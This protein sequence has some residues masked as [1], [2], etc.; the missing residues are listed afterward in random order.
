MN[1][2]NI[3]QD[4]HQL[5][6]DISRNGDQMLALTRQVADINSGSSNLGGVNKVHDFFDNLFADICDQ[7][8]RVELPVVRKMNDL[9]VMEEISTVPA[10]LYKIRPQ[11]PVQILCTGHTDTVFPEDCSFQTT[12]IEGNH[13]RGPGVADM[14]GGLIILYHALKAI[15]DS[16]FASDIGFTVLLSPDEEIGSPASASMLTQLAQQADIGMVYEPALEDGTL[17]G[18]R[19]GSGNFSIAIKGHAT[20]AG[21]QFFQGK[22]AVLAASELSIALAALSNE[23]EGLTVNIG[24]ITGGGAVN[25][26]PD[27]SV[28]HFNCRMNNQDQQA[29]LNE[30]IQRIM[31]QI[32]NSTNCQLSL[33]GGF[34]RPP[35]PMSPIQ[36]KLFEKLK[37][38]GQSLELDIAWQA[39]G[40]CCEGN[41]LAAAGL[42]NIDTLGVRGGS[43]H[44]S[45]EFACIDSFV[46]RAQLNALLMSQMKNF[47]QEVKA[48]C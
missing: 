7:Q 3:Q 39:T 48:K 36:L 37:Q 44:S 11:A 29:M 9:G 40:G 20:H 31:Q 6:D 34:N 33:S 19:K 12:W 1:A 45:D 35:K 30:E 27:L 8:R 10:S 15:Q 26:V 21:R 38:C 25:I 2:M 17:A 28:V 42:P 16:A 14:K 4:H 43:I 22:N 24:R 41:N 23:S 47:V 5:L 32:E 13:L 18:A 46:E